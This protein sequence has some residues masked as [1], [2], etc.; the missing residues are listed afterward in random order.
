[1]LRNAFLNVNV[2][3]LEMERL[4]HLGILLLFDRYV[5][6]SKGSVDATRALAI[7]NLIFRVMVFFEV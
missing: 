5:G 3:D 7:H 2:F 1:M 6:L 4:D